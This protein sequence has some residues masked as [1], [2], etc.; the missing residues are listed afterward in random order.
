MRNANPFTDFLLCRNISAIIRTETG[1]TRNRL[2]IIGYSPLLLPSGVT[3]IM[4]SR[5][6]AQSL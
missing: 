5:N 2:L 6:T 3:K 1:I 4:T